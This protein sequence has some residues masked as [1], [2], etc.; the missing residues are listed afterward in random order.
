VDSLDTAVE[1][2]VSTLL[3]TPGVTAL[4]SSRVYRSGLEPQTAGYPMVTVLA[5]AAEDDLTAAGRYH[6]KARVVLLVKAITMAA[7]DAASYA[8]LRSLA[9]AVYSALHGKSGN[10][11]GFWVGA[12]HRE[13]TIPQDPEQLPGGQTLL[14]L[15]QQF[16][17]QVHPV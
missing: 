11:S 8:A 15:N 4:V 13:R 6:R 14:Y 3:A 10:K 9:A 16:V 2:V 12:C 5:Q 1:W 7:T 17:L